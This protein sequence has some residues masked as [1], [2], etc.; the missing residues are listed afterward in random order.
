M[1]KGVILLLGILLCTCKPE[2]NTSENDKSPKSIVFEQIEDSIDDSLFIRQTNFLPLETNP[3]CI[4]G[5]IRKVIL[6]NDSIYILDSRQNSLLLYDKGNGVFLNKI[7]AIG[8][9]PDE[10]TEINDFDLS[11]I[12]GHAIILCDNKRLLFLDTSLR[13]VNE[14][15]L[16]F[17]CSRFAILN[18]NKFLFYT[19]HFRNLLSPSDSIPLLIIYD[20]ETKVQDRRFMNTMANKVGFCPFDVF[21]HSDK[22]V[23]NHPYTHS[24]YIIEEEGIQDYQIDIGGLNYDFSELIG[25]DASDAMD[26]IF[27]KQNKVTFY[28]NFFFIG[29]W[30]FFQAAY[31]GKIIYCYYNL[32]TDAGYCGKTLD[33]ELSQIFTQRVVGSYNEGIIG[34]ISPEQWKKS[35][36][37]RGGPHGEK[38]IMNLIMEEANPILCFSK[39]R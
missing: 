32:V 9:G 25:V 37:K 14:V 17:Y 31:N 36:E 20:L 35:I 29:N 26:V 10:Y 13:V 38:I 24:F 5:E 22:L 16:P 3:E 19:D 4:I 33:S 1:N 11:T 21:F 2:L 18:N 30:L 7:R 8:K 34:V 28:Q 12:D 27:S 39:F 23:F 6:F 15:K